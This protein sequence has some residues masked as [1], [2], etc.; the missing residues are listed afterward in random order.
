MRS[1][2]PTLAVGLLAV[3]LAGCTGN[4]VTVSGQGYT[5][6]TQSKSLSC[7]P[8]AHIA[9]GVQGAGSMSVSVYDGKGARVFHNSNVGAGQDGQAQHL[10][11]EAGTWKLQVSTGFGYSGQYGITLS[12]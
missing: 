10:K 3:L 6:G 12:C 5:S 1:L 2:A 7:G 8:E 4:A 11:G 9:L